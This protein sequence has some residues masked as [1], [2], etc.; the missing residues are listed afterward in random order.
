MAEQLAPGGALDPRHHNCPAEVWFGS[1]CRIARHNNSLAGSMKAG[2]MVNRG[3][4]LHSIHMLAGSILMLKYFKRPVRFIVPPLNT[5]NGC[6]S[7]FRFYGNIAA[8]ARW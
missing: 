8:R 1:D 3:K 6:L 4:P 5:C 2:K 7:T